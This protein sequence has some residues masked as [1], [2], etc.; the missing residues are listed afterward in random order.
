MV[1]LIGFS[2][3]TVYS[4]DL[5]TFG[6][7]GKSYQLTKHI[8]WILIGSI[9]LITM[10]KVD[11][12]YLQKARI[13]ILVVSFLLILLVLIP[14]IGTVTNGAR[15][16]IR[17]G[18]T[19]G[20]QPSEFAKLAIIIFVSAYIAKNQSRMSE[21]KCGFMIPIII[22]ALAGA[23][24]IKEPDFGSAAFITILSVIMLLVGGTRIIYVFFTII[25]TAPFIHKMLFEV[26]YRKDRLMAFMDPW[27]DP[28]GTG[29][30]II[31][32]WIA[33]GSGGLA[34][35]GVGSSR[36]KL[37]FL[38]ESSNDF[39]FTIIGEE[40]G[41]IGVLAIICLFLSLIWQGL[42]IVHATRDVFGFFLGFGITVMFGLQAIINIA[43][44]SG[45][46]P[47]KGIPLP[48]VGTMPE[49]TAMFITACNPN[50]IVIPNPKKNPNVSL[51]ACT[52]F[53]PCHIND[54][55]RH[56]ITNTPINPNSSPM[57]VKIKSLLLSGKKNSFCLLLPTPN[58]VKP[59]EPRAIHD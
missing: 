31:Q 53:N 32:S 25:A 54:K 52:I 36:Q 22:I 46:V 37:F 8:L 19:F 30:H 33:L 45:I 21:F 23:L 13:P 26:S 55:N 16:W 15:R 41:F 14:G 51:V 57:M 2:I 4:T 5:A 10:S 6:A 40:F 42:K 3:I 47:T 28:S 38:P 27:Q 24:I 44:V 56:I 20:I 34:G 49:T 43:V 9:L 18:H 58:P 50:I 11:Y 1:A 29:Y 35:L 59:P 39:I 12:R 7:G 48:F 17:L